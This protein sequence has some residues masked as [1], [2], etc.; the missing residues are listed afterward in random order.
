MKPPVKTGWQLSEE[1]L[2]GL[3]DL[4]A[5]VERLLADG[6]EVDEFTPEFRALLDC[7]ASTGPPWNLHPVVPCYLARGDVWV[8]GGVKAVTGAIA[9]H[10]GKDR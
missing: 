8:V 3:R 4:L 2:E 7:W 5:E 6:Q 10:V 9:R 1:Q